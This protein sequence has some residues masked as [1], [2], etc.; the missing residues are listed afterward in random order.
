MPCSKTR[1]RRHDPALLV[2][3]TI[4]APAAVSVRA[5]VQIRTGV[6]V[7]PH[8]V[9]GAVSLVAGGMG[10]SSGRMRRALCDSVRCAERA[11]TAESGRRRQGRGRVQIGISGASQYDLRHLALAPLKRHGPL[12]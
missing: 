1:S 2:E 9:T 6:A 11:R 7:V 4:E 8:G 5:T 12:V 10:R 3:I